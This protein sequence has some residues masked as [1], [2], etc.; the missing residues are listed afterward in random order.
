[1]L[2][3]FWT[4]QQLKQPKPGFIIE[5]FGRVDKKEEHKSIKGKWIHIH[6]DDTNW[7]KEAG[8][9]AQ[10]PQYPQE[11]SNLVKDREDKKRE[12]EFY[13]YHYS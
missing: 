4:Y 9:K 6:R 1:M 8:Q 11:S 13:F 3:K 7:S 12:N 5:S 10:A 2:H